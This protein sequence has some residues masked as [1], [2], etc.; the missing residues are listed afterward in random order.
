MSGL[1]EKSQENSLVLV[2]R[3]GY[4]T[5]LLE[6]VFPAAAASPPPRQG[7]GWVFLPG[8]ERFQKGP[9]SVSP[10]VFERQRIPGAVWVKNDSPE[11]MAAKLIDS[12]VEKDPL[13][14]KSVGAS[15]HPITVQV[16]RADP[17]SGA[18]LEST[19]RRLA[20]RL[21]RDKR[22]RAFAA[23]LAS[24]EPVLQVCIAPDG[25][26][27]ALHTASLLTDPY[28]GGVHRMPH[29][30]LAPS[31]SYL[32]VEEALDL[33]D[34]APR[35]GETVVD[36]GAAPGGWSYAFLKRACKVLAVDNGP[37]K[38]PDEFHWAGTIEHIRGDG[39]R[40]RPPERMQP[41]D[42]LVA[43]M[44]IP[45]GVVLGLLRKWIENGW[46]RRFIV[47]VKLPQK[48]PWSALWPLLRLLEETDVVQGQV[49]QL[50]HDR[51]EVTVMGTV[52]DMARKTT[53]RKN[54]VRKTM[55]RK[56]LTR[57][58]AKP[59]RRGGR[60]PVASAKIKANNQGKPKQ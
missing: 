26:W 44:L 7:S 1:G 59:P 24:S 22:L 41:V 14:D 54:I 12:L 2:C 16:Y 31:R 46:M 21:L 42:W 39:L 56:T 11:S 58:P 35:P 60:K 33:M 30:A 48:Q 51:R 4:E 5:H 47:N 6:Q 27:A 13:L 43:D 45:P 23:P 57:K 52:A 10:L 40:Y 20:G 28:P 8:T 32:K 3:P 50:Y 18:V 49:R 29:D 37:L 38:L 36:L 19:T 9:G 55:A 17:D 15:P 34:G 53:A 25:C